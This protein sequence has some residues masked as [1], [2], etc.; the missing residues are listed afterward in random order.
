MR[1]LT[2]ILFWVVALGSCSS[3]RQPADN[4]GQ[5]LAA[6][7]PAA[8]AS[9]SEAEQD[10]S[11]MVV[12]RLLFSQW[13]L[14]FS[15]GPSPD[16]RYFTFVDWE[17]EDLAVHDL[18]TGEQRQLTTDGSL[19][20]TGYAGYPGQSTVSPDGKL[21]AYGWEAPPVWNRELRVIGFDG[22]NARVL[23]T[24]EELHVDPVEWTA[25]GTRIL[26]SVWRVGDPNHQ[27]G[28]VSVES[29]SL[30]VL[31]TLGQ[32]ASFELSISP[33]GRYVIYDVPSDEGSSE[34]DIFVLDVATREVRTLVEHPAD[35]RVLG[36]APDG[37]HVLFVSDRTGTLGAWLMPVADGRPAG[38]ARLVK[39]EM[40][41]IEPLGF[42]RN[43]SFYYGVPM[44]MTDV[45][46]AA[47]DPETGRLLEQPTR[48]SQSFLG[49]NFYPVW[50]PD[51][52]YLAYLSKRDPLE[53]PGT[54]VIVIRSMETGEL[55]ELR[56]GIGP[57]HYPDWSPDGRFILVESSDGENKG[58][59]R[60][61]VQ[62]GEAELA[63]PNA[64]DESFKLAYWRAGGRSIFCWTAASDDRRISIRDLES[65]AEQVLVRDAPDE[66]IIYP[67]FSVS[68]DESRL[69][70]TYQESPENGGDYSLM[71]MS[72]AGG[73]P[74]ALLHFERGSSWPQDIL[75]GPDGGHI[76]YVRFGGGDEYVGL[77]RIPAEGGQPERLDWY[78]EVRP[79][80]MR[81]RP[82]GRRVALNRG[83]Y[84][85]EVWVM[86]DFL[87]ATTGTSDEQ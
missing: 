58:L 81:F 19:P 32:P 48:I 50:S 65:G 84:G 74:H 57:S 69:A 85:S 5:L 1:S 15:G 30:Q 37:R 83:D 23:F 79:R 62:T 12:R 49:S 42:A 82:D 2:G 39:P 8:T 63:V 44:D 77:W 21:V 35:D 28:I 59:F 34:H 47:F 60:V 46:V 6:G 26:V 80:G 70:F 18:R 43:G 86:E 78:D 45:Y 11:P 29:G 16:G 55:R 67:R 64:R 52:R 87:P 10:S 75:W 3:E 33:D 14:D 40:W 17:T 13:N 20:D 68:P 51:G 38:P 56:P 4:G 41:R 31:V 36:W 27:I 25:D 53:R 7:L 72:T 61:D 76:Y 24:N 66:G 54:D 9:A 73:E 71:V 22:S